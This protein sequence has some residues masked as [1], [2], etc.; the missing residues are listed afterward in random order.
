[1][2]KTTKKP[3]RTTIVFAAVLLLLFAGGSQASDAIDGISGTTFNFTAKVDHI[4]TADG[5]S[6]ML[7]G[8]ADDGPSNGGRA[9]YPGPT[10]IVNQG[11]ILTINLTNGL[12]VTGGAV[13]NVSIVFPGHEVTATCTT[14]A[15]PT[16]T[17][18]MEAE[19]D[20]DVVSYSFTATHAGTYMYHSGT[21]PGLQVEMGLTGAIIVRPPNYLTGA[22]P[23]FLAYG[24]ADTAYGH[25][26]LFF[27][28][29]MDPRIHTEV[30]FNGP[31]TALLQ[32][33]LDNY[34]SNYWFINGRTAPDGSITSLLKKNQ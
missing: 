22:P 32:E 27:L 15:C 26:Q 3:T 8:Y 28:T 1:M 2:I 16:G 29:E 31:D 30:E 9:Q 17:L 7:W 6:V 18:T 11:D 20:G 34:F 13:P 23:D 14:G 33:Y 4:S 21:N 10:L 5:G 12:T 19:P 25:E 24:H